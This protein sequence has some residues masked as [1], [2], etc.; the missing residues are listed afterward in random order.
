M[1]AA[2]TSSS[3]VLLDALTLKRAP[4]SIGPD[5]IRSLKSPTAVTWSQDN[6]Y[7]F[8]AQAD[9]IHKFEPAGHHAGLVHETTH[10]ITTIATRDK[11]NSIL[12]NN[13]TEISVFETQS[14]TIIQR[15]TSHKTN[16]TSLSLSNDTTLLASTSLNTVLIHNLTMASH[17]VLR[18]LPS[19]D[20]TTCVFHD[21]HSHPTSYWNWEPIGYL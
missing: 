15:F 2:C 20:I 21:P 4:T 11:G 7:L 3:L 9:G 1:L 13:E 14:G 18:G 19:G 6:S 8:V 5:S 10:P 17:T 16:I 12:F